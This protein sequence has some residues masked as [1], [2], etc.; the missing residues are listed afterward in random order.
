MVGTLTMMLVGV[1]IAV[2]ERCVILGVLVAVNSV[3]IGISISEVR[4]MTV[5]FCRCDRCGSVSCPSVRSMC[6]FFASEFVVSRVVRVR[7]GRVPIGV[8][9]ILFRGRVT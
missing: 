4:M 7:V 3:G 1:L 2:W 9:N 5:S 8:H 6:A